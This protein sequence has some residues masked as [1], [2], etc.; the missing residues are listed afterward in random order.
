[1]RELLTQD[2]IDADKPG[3]LKTRR[4]L[5]TG[6]DMAGILGIRG[7]SATKVYYEKTAG[8]ESPDSMAM[9]LGRH[10]EAFL[11]DLYSGRHPDIH[12]GYAAPSA[13]LTQRGLC[14]HDDRPWQGATFDRLED[15]KPVEFKT[16]VRRDDFGEPPHGQI[17]LRMFIQTLWQG[18]VAQADVVKLVVLFRPFGPFYCYWIPI[19]DEAREDLAVFRQRAEQFRDRYLLPQVPPPADAWADTEKTL[20]RIYRSAEREPAVIPARLRRWLFA[21]KVRRDREQERLDELTNQVAAEMGNAAWA[22]GTD[23]LTAMQ[24]SLSWPSRISVKRLRAE[25]PEVAAACT[26]STPEDEPQ[27]R[28]LVKEPRA[29]ADRSEA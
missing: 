24:R 18:D 27:I 12:P 2:Q 16:A 8:I 3:W 4:E 14:A 15:G 20:K 1:M 9:A 26:D 29:W 21:A 19:D 11:A 13:T 25:H 5:I 6:T 17:P 10:D 7:S 22:I 23:G 28:Y